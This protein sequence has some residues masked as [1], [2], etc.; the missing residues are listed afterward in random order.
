M[1]EWF[2]VH[3]LSLNVDKTIVI[4]FKSNQII[5][6]IAQFKSPVKERKSKK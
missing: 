3:G 1:D 4:H 2:T 5:Y 6:K